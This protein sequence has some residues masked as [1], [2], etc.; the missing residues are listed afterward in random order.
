MTTLQ[1]KVALSLYKNYDVDAVSLEKLEETS[2]AMANRFREDAKAAIDT[3][4]EALLSD[5][6]VKIMT[7]TYDDDN[8]IT[9]ES[10][11]CHDDALKSALKAAFDAA[12]EV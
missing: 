8:W 11:W 5:A 10:A 2:V 7:D 6:M 9:M 12:E 3:V 1:E 4:R